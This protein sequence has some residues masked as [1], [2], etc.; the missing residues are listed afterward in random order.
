MKKTIAGLFLSLCVCFSNPTSG[1]AQTSASAKD[2]SAPQPAVSAPSVDQIIEHAALASGGRDAWAKVTSMYLKGTVEIPLANV[3]GTFESYAQAPDKV[4]QSISLGD[5]VTVKQGSDGATAWKTAPDRSIVDVQGDELENAKLDSDFYSEVDLKRLYPQMV[6]QNDATIGGRPVYTVLATPR[7][8]IP[9]KFYFD[10]E[11]G[12]RVGMSMETIEEGQPSQV[13]TY[14]ADFKTVEGIQVPFTIRLVSK[15]FTMVFHLHDV[16]ANVPIASSTFLK[17]ASKAAPAPS[18]S[19]S[20]P[21]RINA[22]GVSDNTYT[23]SLFGF[24]YTFPAGWTVHGDATNK[25][26]MK[27]GRNMMVGDDPAKQA[28]YDASAERTSQLLTVFQYPLGTPGKVN[29]SVQVIAE[30]VDFAPGIRNGKDYLLILESAMKKGTVPIDFAD[31][32]TEMTFGG[33]KFYRLDDQ[34]H[35]P[36]GT[37]HQAFIATRLDTHTLSFVLSSHSQ[38]DLESLA[39][40]LNSLRFPSG[41]R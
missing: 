20:A 28:A 14:Y 26:I 37:V 25:E 23:N 11:T 30:R 12:L 32:I 24:S 7:Q 6:L 19:A 1:R 27:A 8:G 39:G 22:A 15:E 33:K 4:Y 29:Q 17:P 38:E 2:V 40:T 36:G 41:S 21:T 34:M 5:A 9:R 16:R 35:F 31:D 10:K 13:K 3:E 18:E